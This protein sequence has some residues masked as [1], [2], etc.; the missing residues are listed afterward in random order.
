MTVE[1]CLLLQAETYYVRGSEQKHRIQKLAETFGAQHLL[2]KR[3]RELSLGERMRCEIVASLVHKPKVIL[4]DEPTIGLDIAAKLKLRESLKAWQREEKTTMLLT[5]HDLSDVEA[6]C[7]RCI[8]INHGAKA[9]DGRLQ[10]VKGD[11]A[12]VRRARLMLNEPAPS[13]AV[14]LDGLIELSTEN[15]MEKCFEFRLER[16]PLP[17]VMEF[18]SANYGSLLQDIQIEGVRLEEVIQKHYGH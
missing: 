7:D 17:R 10:N 3:V 11:L 13:A 1:Q 5:S 9:Y 16:T 15:A 8:L 18:L 2:N 14:Q 4:L 12:G 6:L